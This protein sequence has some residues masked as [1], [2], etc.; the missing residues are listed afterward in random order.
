MMTDPILPEYAGNPFIARLPPPMSV[1]DV[2]AELTDLPAYSPDERH[3]PAHLRCHC[4]RRLA[5]YFVR[6]PSSGRPAA[7][8]PTSCS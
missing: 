3:Y 4:I 2:L 5:R 8:R 1:Q 6:T 7:T